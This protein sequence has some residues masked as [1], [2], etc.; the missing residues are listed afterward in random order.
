ME[1]KR[2]PGQL[3]MRWLDSITN[4]MDMISDKLWE[5][6]RDREAGCV[7]RV[8]HGLAT[9][10]HATSWVN[11]ENIMHKIKFKKKTQK[12]KRKHYA[13]RKKPDTRRHI[14]S[15]SIYMIYAERIFI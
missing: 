11:I 5:I 14:L 8:G 13:G 10:Q 2:R 6:V 15:D 3:R 9:E 4:S 7:Q 1:S 12:K